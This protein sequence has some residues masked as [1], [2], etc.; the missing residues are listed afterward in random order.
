MKMERP[1]VY[2]YRRE[3]RG[4]V[5]RIPISFSHRAGVK[6]GSWS[7]Q[8]ARGNHNGDADMKAYK[9]TLSLKVFSMDG[10]S[11]RL[12]GKG[13]IWTFLLNSAKQPLFYSRK[14]INKA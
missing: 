10:G 12:Q 11:Y 14:S 1:S 3:E 2:P 7:V 13:R 5:S 9:Q 8:V 4:F 6:T